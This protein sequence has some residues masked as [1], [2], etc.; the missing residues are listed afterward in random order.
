MTSISDT[1]YRIER[2][3]S[4]WVVTFSAMAGPCE[5]LL[6]CK[7]KSEARHLASLSYLE[8]QRIERKFSRYRDDNTVYNI[9]N[10]HGKPVSVD[11]EF[12][13]LFNYVDQCYKIS[14][15]LFDITSGALR[16]AWTF[17]GA[18]VTPDEELIA[19]LQKQIG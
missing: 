17:N 12:A 1:Q 19:S 2:G 13:D 18:E 4:H 10:T 14:N 9:N 11:K 7:E 8:T 15:G 3:S 16:K 6:R 5:I